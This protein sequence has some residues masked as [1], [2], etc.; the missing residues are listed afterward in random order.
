VRAE[1]VEPSRAFASPTD[2][3]AT[4]AFAAALGVRGLDYP[5]TVRTESG[6][7]AARLVSTP[8]RPEAFR[9]GLGS[10]SPL[11]GSPTLGSS[12][13]PVSRRALKF[14]SSPLRLPVPPHPR[15]RSSD[16]VH[17]RATALSGRT[18]SR[19]SDTLCVVG[20]SW[21]S[22]LPASAAS[23][24][25]RLYGI[26]RAVYSVRKDVL[27]LCD[28]GLVKHMKTQVHSDTQTD[29]PTDAVH[30]QR[31][32]R[33]PR[34]RGGLGLD[35]RFLGEVRTEDLAGLI[36]AVERARLQLKRPCGRRKRA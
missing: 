10:G 22:L 29:A 7:G 23:P 24:R 15:G 18:L 14:F 28:A 6:G 25:D 2:F 34:E 11:Q 26:L 4:S 9:S 16:A 21:L 3:H 36:F 17:D 12:A 20:R 1:G 13:S 32:R 30:M 19:S 8:S 33:A 27:G 5:F 31:R 35:S